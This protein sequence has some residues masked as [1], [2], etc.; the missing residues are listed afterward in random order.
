MILKRFK[1]AIT[2]GDPSGVGPEI[3]VKMFANHDI[4]KYADVFVIGDLFPMLS[5]QRR[6]ST[7]MAIKPI[8][9]I[10]KLSRDRNIINLLD[11][12]K[13]HIDD[14]RI[15]E[16]GARAGRASYE[17][18]VSSIE[19]A[20]DK[21][22]DAVVT[23]PINKHSLHMAG[24]K[25][26]GHTEIFAKFT[27]TKNYAMML[28]GDSLKVVLATIHT[29]IKNVPEEITTKR[30]MSLIQLTGRSLSKDFGIKDPAIAVCGLNPHAGEA[31]AFGDEEAKTITPAVNMAK[32]KGIKVEG[33]YPADTI[34]HKVVKYKTHD[35][36]IAMYHDQGLVALKLLS[37]D[38]GVNVTL[39][40][41]IIRTSP[42]HGTAYDIAGTGMAGDG[43]IFE[44]FKTALLMA[45]NRKKQ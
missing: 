31:G 15:G 41:P 18:I 13:L 16:S 38:S 27:K 8:T 5:A 11:L 39:G 10:N 2:M 14:Y 9:D 33:P 42:D 28:M 32:K 1:I 37:F 3:I 26:P 6:V 36:V 22:I 20:M 44:A 12:K 24:I 30:L 25:F 19:L 35:A 34:F 4:Y 7:K 23:A 40:L 45:I 17:Y 21:K 43:S 29:A